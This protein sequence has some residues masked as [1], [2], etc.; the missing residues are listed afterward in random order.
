MYSYF[1]DTRLG[2]AICLA[3]PLPYFLGMA[4]AGKP[5]F[6]PE[7]FYPIGPTGG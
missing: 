4:V 1:R 6:S 7:K 5:P 2:G 3:V